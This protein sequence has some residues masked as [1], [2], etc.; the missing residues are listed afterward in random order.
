MAIIEPTVGMKFNKKISRP[1]DAGEI[2]FHDA[3]KSIAKQASQGTGEHL[4][5]D[6]FLNV[7]AKSD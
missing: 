6:V 7:V 5:A 1:Q 3:Q 4:D 2:D